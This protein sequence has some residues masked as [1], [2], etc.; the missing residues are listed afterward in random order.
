MD[1]YVD[2][3]DVGGPGDYASAINDDLIAHIDANYRTIGERGGR[4]PKVCSRGARDAVYEAGAL[5]IANLSARAFDGRV[6]GSLSLELTEGVPFETRLH[7]LGQVR[8]GGR[9]LDRDHVLLFRRA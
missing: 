6:T 4:A 2:S 3:A 8:A 1:W 7:G 5:K 9:R